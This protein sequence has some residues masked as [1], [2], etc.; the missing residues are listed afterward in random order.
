MDQKIAIVACCDPKMLPGACCALL[1]ASRHIH[2]R[3][4]SY[5]LVVRDAS[6]A[7]RE[8]VERFQ[9]VH[10]MRIS[11]SYLTGEDMFEE[12]RGF[13]AYA[14]RLQLDGLLD[15][16][17]ERVLYLDSDTIVI[18]DL[19]PLFTLDFKGKLI[20]A[21][22]D[23]MKEIPHNIKRCESL[24]LKFGQYF[25]SGIILFHW[26]ACLADHLFDKTRK[27]IISRKLRIPDQ[28]ALNEVIANRWLRLPVGWN[29]GSP[30]H[31]RLSLNPKIV[32]FTGGGKGRKPWEAASIA[33]HKAY[34]AFYHDA[35]ADTP[36]NGFVQPGRW[37]DRLQGEFRA[38][39]E[40][41][42]RYSNVVGFLKRHKPEAV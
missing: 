32:H 36:W 16:S 6:L 42:R 31:S 7:D 17:F 25:N 3:D 8:A 4:V 41:I 22:D 19:E 5:F 18:A 39:I 2:G 34:R 28:D 12:I 35:L 14:L 1:S 9:H 23:F 33:L 24:G 37:Q 20:A 21:V 10:Q 11:V 30:F 13:G 26:P 38:V 27:V 15:E 40:G 29:F